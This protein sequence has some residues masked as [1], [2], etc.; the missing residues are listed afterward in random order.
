MTGRSLVLLGALRILTGAS[1]AEAQDPVSLYERAVERASA[2]DRIRALRLL[3]SVSR[4]P[5]GL[6]PSFHR[7]FFPYHDDA[8]FRRIIA[9]IR[10]A[11]PPLVRSSIAWTIGERD[12]HPEGIAFDPVSRSAFVGSFKGKIVRLDSTG[13]ATDFA[14]VSRPEAPRVVVGVRVDA[15]RRHLWAAV[16][17]PRAFADANVEGAS[18]VQFDI[19]TGR[20]LATHRGARGAFNDVTVASDGTAFATNTTDGSI[21][22]VVPGGS[23]EQFLPRGTVDGANGITLSADGRWLFVAGALDIVRI[24]VRSRSLHRLDA[25]EGTVLGSFDGLYWFDDGL[26]GIQNGLHPGRVVRLQLDETRARVTRAETLERYHPRF[27]GMTTAALDGRSLLYLVNTQSRSFDGDGRP[28]PGVAL[29]EIL[30]A[31]L[32]LPA[33]GAPEP[34]E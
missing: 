19:A 18:L 29:Q 32:P 23:L 4:A 2:G 28:K 22:R 9:R 5:G 20:T 27:G 26:V 33:T 1:I 8:A 24:E 10:D 17:E 21:W 13:R 7:A 31:R 30:I 16:D 12:L 11:N 25:P 3:D 14:W 34:H 6:D 15:E